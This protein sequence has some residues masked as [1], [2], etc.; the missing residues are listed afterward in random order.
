MTSRANFVSFYLLQTLGDA[1]DSDLCFLDN[2]I[3]GLEPKSWRIA[4]GER[5]GDL[6]PANAK[7]YM[8]DENPGIKLGDLIG[9]SRNMIVASQ[10]LKKL[11]Q[12]HCAQ[13]D[14]EYLPF[15]LYD[16]RKRVYSKDYCLINP[17][18]T[19]DCLDLK[20]SKLLRDDDNP[21]EILSVTTPV[22]DKNKVKKAPQL[23]RMKYQPTNYVL[24]YDL[25]KDIHDRNLPNV[26]WRKLKF[27]DGSS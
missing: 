13:Q 24:G 25:A 15:T 11:V 12:K 10:E 21:D 2:F 1:N 19:F 14:I 26:I 23:F 8:D 5:F 3:D 7:L 27:A 20:A 4:K 9:T 16:H 22:L 6:Y 18:G 17:I